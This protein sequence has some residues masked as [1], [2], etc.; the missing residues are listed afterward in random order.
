[1]KDE[2][3]PQII[4]TEEDLLEYAEAFEIELEILEQC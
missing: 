3:V 4:E 2:Q 1:M